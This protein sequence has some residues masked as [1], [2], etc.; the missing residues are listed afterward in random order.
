MDPEDVLTRTAALPDAVL[1]YAGHDDGVVDLRLPGGAG[2]WPLVVVV[3]GGFW[4]Q[5]Y[6]RKHARPMADALAA[7]GFLVASVE[8]RRVGGAGGWP[9]TAEDVDT[10]LAKLPGLLEGLGVGT[11]TTTLLGHSAG[12]HLVLWLASQGHRVDRVVALAPVGDLRHAAAAHL[13]D[14]AVRDLLGGGPEEV[15][16]AYDAADPAVRLM[17]RPGLDLVM[18]HGTADDVVPLTNSESLVARHPY[19]D[20]RVLDGVDHFAVIDPASSAWSAVVG[21]VR[22]E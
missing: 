2:P 7:Q 12:G 13:G 1:R 9:V 10:A 17:E 3:H 14:D 16:A 5:G 15:P 19:V 6:D 4:R 21:A 8:Y 18:V 20:L 22:G 11:T